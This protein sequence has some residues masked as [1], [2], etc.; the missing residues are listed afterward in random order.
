MAAKKTKKKTTEK[1]KKPKKPKVPSESKYLKSDAGYL[2]ETGDLKS[3][4]ARFLSN[5]KAAESD[6]ETNFNT[7]LRNLGYQGG[8]WN[9]SDR[10][11]QYGSAMRN[12]LEDFTGRGMRDSTFFLD[13]RGDQQASF[14]R[15]LA[16]QQDARQQQLASYGRQREDAA[17]T[18]ESAM[19]RARR[20]ALLRRAARYGLSV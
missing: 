20:D 17:A 18:K 5:L 7:A 14:N 6:Y 15:R 13:A 12:Q 2:Q 8:K 16:E 1:P 3:Q 11:S 19:E 9:E 10:L 4:Y